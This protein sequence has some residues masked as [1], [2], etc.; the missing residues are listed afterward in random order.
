MKVKKGTVGPLN[1]VRSMLTWGRSTLDH[2]LND[3]IW[4][5]YKSPAGDYEAAEIDIRHKVSIS[6]TIKNTDNA[7]KPKTVE[8]AAKLLAGKTVGSKNFAPSGKGTPGIIAAARQYLQAANNDITNLF[9]GDA[10]VNRGIGRRYDPGS[11]EDPAM[12]QQEFVNKWGFKDEEF[13]ITIERKSK[14]RGTTDVT[15]TLKPQAVR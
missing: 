15:K 10:R 9:L 5:K 7:I 6:D 12:Q 8:E 4:N 1:I 11:G 14:K 13:T 3:P 2:F